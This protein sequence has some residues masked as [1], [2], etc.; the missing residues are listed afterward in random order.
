M[1]IRFSFKGIE[2]T[3][4]LIMRPEISAYNG[5]AVVKFPSDTRPRLQLVSIACH[6]KVQQLSPVSTAF[7]KDLGTI[8]LSRSHKTAWLDDGYCHK[9]AKFEII[10]EEHEKQ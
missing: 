2:Y 5:L 6:D 3:V 8:R 10:G 1:K 7:V 9:L 4:P